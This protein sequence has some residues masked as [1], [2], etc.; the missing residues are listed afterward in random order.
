MCMIVEGHN[1]ACSGSP[2]VPGHGPRGAVVWWHLSVLAVDEDQM[3]SG[4][5]RVVV[6]VKRVAF[7]RT[8]GGVDQA[9]GIKSRREWQR[10]KMSRGSW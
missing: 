3:K 9:V 1:W 10:H 6:M 7:G 5:V 4:G 8:A 2:A